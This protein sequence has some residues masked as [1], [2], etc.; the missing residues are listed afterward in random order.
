[1]VLFGAKIDAISKKKGLRRNRNGFV[2]DGPFDGFSMGFSHA[3]SMGLSLQSINQSI[4]Q[5]YFILSQ[6]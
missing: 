2:F 5:S 3:F 4:N 6:N 1:M